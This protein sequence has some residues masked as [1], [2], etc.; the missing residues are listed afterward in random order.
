MNRNVKHWTTYRHLSNTIRAFNYPCGDMGSKELT[1]GCASNSGGHSS[2][3]VRIGC[4][5][6]RA[7]MEVGQ[8]LCGT[9]FPVLIHRTEQAQK[10][11]W[12]KAMPVGGCQQY[13]KTLKAPQTISTKVQ[14]N[15]LHMLTHLHEEQKPNLRV[16]KICLCKG[17][18]QSAGGALSS[19]SMLDSGL[20]MSFPLLSDL[21]V[22]SYFF[23]LFFFLYY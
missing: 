17:A 13:Q 15:R 22:T 2:G 11:G 12:E 1:C 19:G 20:E 18:P 5:W 3:Q 8:H 16:G 6:N 10:R 7:C 14:K 21:T 4:G 23:P 9:D